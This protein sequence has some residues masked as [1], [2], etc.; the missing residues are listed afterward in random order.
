MFLITGYIVAKG[1]PDFSMEYWHREI[2]FAHQDQPGVLSALVLLDLKSEKYG[3]GKHLIH[4]NVY[5]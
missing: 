3:N 5:D 1:Y 4:V 2:L